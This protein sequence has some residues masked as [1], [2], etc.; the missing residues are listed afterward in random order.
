MTFI[1]GISNALYQYSIGAPQDVVVG[2][3]LYAIGM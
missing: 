1:N 2:W 3:L